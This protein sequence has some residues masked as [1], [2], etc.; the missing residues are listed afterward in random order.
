[1]RSP[2]PGMDPYLEDPGGWPGVHDGLIAI[3]REQLNQQLGPGY[4]AD[5]GTTVYVLTAETLQQ[6]NI[7][8]RNRLSR[9]VVAI[10][11]ILSPVNKGAAGGSPDAGSAW[12]DFRRKRRDTM[13]SPTHWLEIDLLRAGDRP[14]EVRGL[15]DYYAL[16]KRAGPHEVEV[17][18]CGLRDPLPTVAV[19]LGQREADVPLDLHAALDALFD[20]YRY[21][22]LLDYTAPVP[23]PPL[24]AEEARWVEAQVARW[25]AGDQPASS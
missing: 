5:G 8:I 21:A 10:I 19:P 22:E 18:P 6:P 17:W 16:L 14:P 25:T 11:E 4:I 1:M 7:L 24:R 3:L 9:A 23:L 15:G 13:A 20:R 2:F 12:A